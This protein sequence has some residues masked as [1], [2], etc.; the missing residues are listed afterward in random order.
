MPDKTGTVP[1]D[2]LDSKFAFVLAAAKRA[3]QLQ[4]GAKPL[5]QTTGHKPTRIAMEETF[6]GAVPYDLPGLEEGDDEKGKKK[7]RRSK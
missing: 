3:R 6:Q 2:K 4:A 5:V 1:L 7:A